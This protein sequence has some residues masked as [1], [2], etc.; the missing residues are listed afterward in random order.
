MVH[1]VIN[2][3]IVVSYKVEVISKDDLL[4]VQTTFYKNKII[5]KMYLC[6]VL[7]I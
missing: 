2:I 4:D 1:I 6:S 3:R 7:P 5:N